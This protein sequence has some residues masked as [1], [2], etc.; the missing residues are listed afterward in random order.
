MLLKIILHTLWEEVR[1]YPPKE[2][3]ISA[4]CIT[5]RQITLACSRWTYWF[6]SK[7]VN[8]HQFY[9]EENVR[10][11][12]KIIRA[13]IQRTSRVGKLWASEVG[14]V[15]GYLRWQRKVILVGDRSDRKDS[16]TLLPFYTCETSSEVE[17]RYYQIPPPLL[18]QTPHHNVSPPQEG[19]RHV[20]DTPRLTR[21]QA[22]NLYPSPGQTWTQRQ[23]C[24]P[25]VGINMQTQIL[26]SKGSVRLPSFF[27]LVL[28]P[29]W[30]VLCW[31][32]HLLVVIKTTG[33][34][35]MTI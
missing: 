10:E 21:Q 35:G 22:A 4:R 8:G 13:A 33:V 3:N 25:G 23:S 29:L 30:F 14:T 6:V 7:Q 18:H 20:K 2:G 34:V 31:L 12:N 9:D 28:P 5:C 24:H 1:A 17:H 11:R 16:V 27:H 26:R 15:E 32:S 19:V